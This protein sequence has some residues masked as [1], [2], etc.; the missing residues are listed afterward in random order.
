[1]LVDGEVKRTKGWCTATEDRVPVV[2][3]KIT[4]L[5]QPLPIIDVSWFFF[6]MMRSP[7]TNLRGYYIFPF[8]PS[9]DRSLDILGCKTLCIPQRAMSSPIDGQRIGTTLQ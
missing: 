7:Q 6:T 3:T 9:P 2:L 4:S 1:M 5:R 8:Y